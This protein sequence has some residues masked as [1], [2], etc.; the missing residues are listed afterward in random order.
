M[1]VKEILAHINSGVSKQ[2][3]D[4]YRK[5]ANAYDAFSTGPGQHIASMKS[6]ERLEQRGAE[7][8]SSIPVNAM[9][10]VRGKQDDER[11]S[12]R[13]KIAQEDDSDARRG[14]ADI[15][16]SQDPSINSSTDRSVQ[17]PRSDNQVKRPATAPAA[18][19]DPQTFDPWPLYARLEYVEETP[20]AA[21]AIE[22]QLY[23]SSLIAMDERAPKT[24][25]SPLLGR[26]EREEA[27]NKVP[28]SSPARPSWNAHSN[29][30]GSA[31]ENLSSQEILDIER[32]THGSLQSSQTDGPSSVG[33]GPSH[34]SAPQLQNIQDE[35]PAWADNLFDELSSAADAATAAAQSSPP[36]QSQEST[37]SQPPPQSQSQGTTNKSQ[38][39]DELA[40]M[41]TQHSSL[42]EICYFPSHSPIADHDPRTRSYMTSFLSC[43]AVTTN[44]DSI[45][46]SRAQ[47]YRS[48]NRSPGGGYLER[49]SWRFIITTSGTARTW[50]QATEDR[51]LQLM[52][53]WVEGMML[54]N[55]ITFAVLEKAVDVPAEDGQ[56]KMKVVMKQFQLFCQEEVAPHAFVLLW[57]ASESW[58][59]RANTSWVS[60]EDGKVKVRMPLIA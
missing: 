24:P 50:S 13:T 60:C 35:D 14:P 3:D 2:D 57:A 21:Q 31:E 53:R 40:I 58:I 43:D 55:M 52:R 17:I 19:Q 15:R 6:S 29:S 54:G 7:L 42:D 8:A 49:G 44:L 51:F 34:S 16:S 22:S 36:C 20:L 26:A 37:L 41:F 32:N 9:S 11:P 18:A 1:P 38:P 47:V 48:F 33:A 46:Y 25:S 23:T 59:N 12:K 4:R 45:Y 56:G 39:Q 27:I 28:A 30:Q 10:N 5:L